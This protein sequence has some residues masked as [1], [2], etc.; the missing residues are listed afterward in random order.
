MKTVKYVATHPINSR[1]FLLLI[2]LVI[3]SMAFSQGPAVNWIE[4]PSVVDL[5]DNIA[6][7]DF[8]SNYVFADAADTRKLMQFIGNP[9]TKMEVGLV[10]PRAT[11]NE[12]FMIFEFNPIGYIRDAEKERIDADAILKSIKQATDQSNKQRAE[13]GFPALNVLGWHTE[14]HYDVE[15]NNLVWALLADE[16]G[17]RIVN[18]NTRLLGRHG[19]VSAVLVTDVKTFESLSYDVHE[20]LKG[21]SFKT[22]KSYAE[23]VKG[24]KLAKLGLT[25]LIVGGTAAAATKFGLLKFL[26]K[27]GKYILMIIFGLLAAVWGAIK[28]VFR[29]KSE[30][31]QD[32]TSSTMMLPLAQQSPPDP[33][34]NPAIL[35][36]AN[37]LIEEGRLKDAFVLMKAA[38]RGKK[39]E[40][41]ELAKTYYDLLKE[42]GKRPELL[43]H[44][45]AY[46]DILID[47]TQKA[48]A[49]D[50]YTECL[51]HDAQFTPKPD[52]F[53][54]IAQSLA[55]RGETKQAVN[56]CLRLTKTYPEHAVLP[57]VYFFMAKVLN[58]KLN[59]K[60]K[61]KKIISWSTKKYP[62]HKTTPMA[63]RYLAAIR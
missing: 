1:L 19:Y 16:G 13:K 23:Y 54:K 50:V 29:G 28:A 37:Q 42:N 27:G 7:L 20:I 9:A 35:N 51:V 39:I 58:E 18:Y 57:E 10:A 38:L 36:K 31:Q 40:N 15:T 4:G 21:F 47:K 33:A 24:D 34:P 48:S 60:I 11:D 55:Q 44:A 2:I 5:G 43:T 49:R 8:A 52:S 41:L 14:P 59:N 56:A 32:S 53:F 30:T 3:P 63:K 61:A 22:G 6:Q 46:I 26:A 12:W 17:Q 62:D 45:K 25:A